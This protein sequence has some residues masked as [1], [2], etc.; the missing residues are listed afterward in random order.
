M[1][2]RQILNLLNIHLSSNRLLLTVSPR[3]WNKHTHSTYLL[4]VLPCTAISATWSS[5]TNQSIKVK[6]CAFSI[7]MC[8]HIFCIIDHRN[9]RVPCLIVQLKNDGLS[10]VDVPCFFFIIHV[11]IL[12][13]FP[14]PNCLHT[15]YQCGTCSQCYVEPKLFASNKSLLYLLFLLLTTPINQ[16]NYYQFNSKFKTLHTHIQIKFKI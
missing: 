10:Q 5:N 2:K 7:H 1:A 8:R 4:N 11:L 14:R 3:S 16:I 13:Q 9:F 12:S 6:H 15:S